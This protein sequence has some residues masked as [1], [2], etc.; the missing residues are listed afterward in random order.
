MEPVAI[1]EPPL[2]VQETSY[3][4][5]FNEDDDEAIPPGDNQGSLQNLCLC[6]QNVCLFSGRLARRRG[7]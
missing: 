7:R 1:Q 6:V 5:D 4:A 3:T 2:A